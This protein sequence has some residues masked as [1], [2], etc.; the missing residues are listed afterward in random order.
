MS[1]LK[2]VFCST[3]FKLPPAPSIPL[4]PFHLTESPPVWMHFLAGVWPFPSWAPCPFLCFG[5]VWAARGWVCQ[6]LPMPFPPGWPQAQSGLGG[7]F[8]WEAGTHSCG[9]VLLS[10]PSQDILTLVY[11]QQGKGRSLSKHL[12][13]ACSLRV[14]EGK[15]PSVTR[16]EL[17][18]VS[19]TEMG[20]FSHFPLNIPL[21]PCQEMIFSWFFKSQVKYFIICSSLFTVKPQI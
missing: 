5:M 12:Y 21:L 2:S 9:S 11:V 4:L 15:S 8:I 6:A 13:I 10:L 16:R 14:W 3:T 19:G 1:F 20:M 7:C 17:F 18:R